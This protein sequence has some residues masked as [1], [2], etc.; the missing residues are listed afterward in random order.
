MPH[1]ELAKL[2]QKP[3]AQ[4][5]DTHKVATMPKAPPVAP[6]PAPEQPEPASQTPPA[7][8]VEK[9]AV[10]VSALMPVWVRVK[11]DGKTATE[12]IVAKGKTLSFEA[13][14]SIT[15]RAGM[16]GAVQIKVN[17][18]TQPPLGT[19]KSPGEKTY[20]L[21]VIPAQPPSAAQ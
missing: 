14:K 21:P 1:R 4:S 15:V 19:L 18:Q 9:L 3:L 12:Q 8:A 10:D 17:G 5:P 11:V 16:A 20:T 2:R 13:D 6:P 7:P